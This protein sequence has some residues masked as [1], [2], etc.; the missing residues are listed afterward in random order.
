MSILNL[1]KFESLQFP[2][3]VT[4]RNAVF[5]CMWWSISENL[6]IIILFI[7]LIFFDGAVAP[8]GPE[9]PQTH[10]NKQ[11]SSGLVISPTQIPL[12]D[13]AQHTR[14]PFVPPTVFETSIPASKRPQTDAWRPRGHW[15]RLWFY[16][17]L[18][19]FRHPRGRL[20]VWRSL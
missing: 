16:C 12:T 4:K 6:F 18:I 15:D 2:N 11:D 20:S 14:Q 7:L 17:L 10:H 8:V 13:N 3:G 19:K 1:Y 9:P 5:F